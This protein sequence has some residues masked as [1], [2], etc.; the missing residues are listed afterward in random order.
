MPSLRNAIYA[1]LVVLAVPAAYATEPAG[2]YGGW[3]WA[4]AK[5]GFTQRTGAAGKPGWGK[6]P[7]QLAG[8]NSDLLT[9]DAGTVRIKTQ[10]ELDADAA[11]EAADLQTSQRVNRL[12]E[13][14]AARDSLAS[15]QA[16]RAEMNGTKI[17]TRID[18]RIAAAQ[19]RRDT[20]FAALADL[21]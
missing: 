1:M 6:V 4:H 15:L 8:T 11:T 2:P 12:S 19:T 16:A 18:A 20:A 13:F 3:K 17:L 9:I 10:G 21:P 5:N 7:A 14:V